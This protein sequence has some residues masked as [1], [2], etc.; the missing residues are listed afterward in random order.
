MGEGRIREV[1]EVC[2]NLEVTPYWA[3]FFAMQTVKGMCEKVG[4]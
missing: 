4:R 3:L 1:G 2:R